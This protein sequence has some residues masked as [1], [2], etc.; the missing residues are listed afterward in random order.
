MQ[1]PVALEAALAVHP[2]VERIQGPLFSQLAHRGSGRP[3]HVGSCCFDTDDATLLKAFEDG[4]CEAILA[5][6]IKT[7]A[8]GRRVAG[9]VRLDVA[10]ALD[11]SL[12]AL[13]PV[14]YDGRRPVAAAPARIL[15][16]ADAVRWFP[17][18]Q[19]LDPRLPG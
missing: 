4:R 2:A 14:R 18:L 17:V 9:R 11:G 13:Q 10:V 1:E 5:L 19:S 12:A 3:L 7:D 8:T 15:T 16:G 6:P